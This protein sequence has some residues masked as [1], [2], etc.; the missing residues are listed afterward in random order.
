MQSSQSVIIILLVANLVA[1]IW[2]GAIKGAAPTNE[3]TQ[4]ASVHNLPEMISSDVT[5]KIFNQFFTAFNAKDYDALYNIFGPA[6]KAQFDKTSS[7]EV[8][9]KL[10]EYFDSIIEGGFTH[11]EFLGS[12]GNM[13]QYNLYYAVK[14]SEKSTFGT[15]GT[16]KVTIVVREKD[17]EIYG[18]KLNA[19]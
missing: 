4:S 18:Y 19:G 10:S 6:A 15:K 3:V 17:Y 5:L 8:L 1:T 7:D 12:Q 11:S 13:S 2:F 14:L 9:D 16:L